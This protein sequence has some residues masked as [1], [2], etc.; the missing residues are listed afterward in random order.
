MD[1]STLDRYI[2]LENLYAERV[3]W[4][5]KSDVQ[6]VEAVHKEAVNLFSAQHWVMFALE[7]LIS[8]NLNDPNHKIFYMHRRLSFLSRTFPMANYTTAWL[9]EELG[10]A[11]LSL[12]R[13]ETAISFFERGYWTLRILC[14]A[15]HPFTE[16]AHVKW[17]EALEQLQ[18]SD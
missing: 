10:D 8:Q 15:D 1:H 13:I 6:D 5:D 4:I 2:E 18:G 9:L 14:G 11:Y 3:A 7:T 16:S 12:G 17:D